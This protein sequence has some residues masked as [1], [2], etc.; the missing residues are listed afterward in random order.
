[1]IKIHPSVSIKHAEK[2]KLVE[3]MNSIVLASAKNKDKNLALVHK[4]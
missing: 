4:L 1:M 3:I 2:S